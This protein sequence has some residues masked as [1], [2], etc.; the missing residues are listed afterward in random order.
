MTY[1]TINY[2]LNA[3]SSCGGLRGRANQYMCRVSMIQDMFVWW[4]RNIHVYIVFVWACALLVEIMTS[5]PIKIAQMLGVDKNL[6]D[7]NFS[8]TPYCIGIMCTANIVTEAAKLVW[9][10][11]Q[12]SHCKLLVAISSTM[13]LAKYNKELLW[14]FL[15]FRGETSTL[16]YHQKLSMSRQVGGLWGR[17]AHV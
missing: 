11:L 6:R 16:W 3:L 10:N 9:I 7:L 13:N 4:K 1:W 17:A 5:L 12:W 8:M 2:P 14:Y 15:K